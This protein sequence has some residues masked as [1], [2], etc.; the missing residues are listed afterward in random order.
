MKSSYDPNAL[1]L[2]NRI[3][4]PKPYNLYGK[5]RYQKL[6]DLYGVLFCRSVFNGTG[7]TKLSNTELASL[8]KISVRQAQYHVR[9]LEELGQIKT[10]NVQYFTGAGIRTE[11]IIRVLAAHAHI[12][13]RYK[14]RAEVFGKRWKNGFDYSLL[15]N[16]ILEDMNLRHR[17][18]VEVAEIAE[19]PDW[20]DDPEYI[21]RP[22]FV[23]AYR[24][25]TD[26]YETG[27]DDL[28]KLREGVVP[29]FLIM[30]Y[31]E[32]RAGWDELDTH[33]ILVLGGRRA[34]NKTL[35]R[36][37]GNTDEHVSSIET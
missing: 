28:A 15:D 31:N 32:W 25:I 6:N 17:T 5:L 30:K 3:G 4:A 33:A 14:P 12:N 21:N 1:K 27:M 9:A 29:G 36:M 23:E 7:D 20:A 13:Y 10:F 35:K 37:M 26:I 24:K 22:G 11:R 2:F 8:V 18:T 19:I 16:I 34:V